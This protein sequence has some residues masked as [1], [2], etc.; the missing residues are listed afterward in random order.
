MKSDQS[1]CEVVSD[2]KK[3]QQCQKLLENILIKKYHPRIVHK[4]RASDPSGDRD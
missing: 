4:I 1:V 3:L 2:E